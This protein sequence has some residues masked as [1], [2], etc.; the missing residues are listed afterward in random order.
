MVNWTGANLSLHHFDR[1]AP[2]YY[3]VDELGDEAAKEL[4]SE[5][6]FAESMQ[7][8]DAWSQKDISDINNIPPSFKKML[9]QMQHRPTWVNDDELAT[10]ADLCCRSG[11]NALV[12]LR[13]FTLMGGYDYAYLNKPLIFTGSLKKGATKRLKDTLN[14]WVNVTRPNGLNISHVGFKL[15]VITRLMHSYSRLMIL[16]KVK[17]WDSKK[18]GL[19]I[20]S[21]DMIATYIGFSLTFVL[22]LRKLGVK[23]SQKEEDSIFHLWNYVGYLIGIPHEFIPNN[24]KEATEQ[25]Y[26]WSTVQDCSDADSVMLAKSL[27][28]ENLSTPVYETM[29][30]RKRL[31][32]LHTCCIWYLLDEEVNH[33][34]EIP[35]V[36]FANA[37]PNMLRL[38]NKLYQMRQPIHKQVERGNAAQ[39]KILADYLSK[40]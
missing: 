10:A 12:I 22:G 6:S 3:Q 19:P 23:I 37:F 20:N 16:D 1:F 31:K 29:K 25:F 21:W 8:I 35:K 28:D 18:W 38:R 34:L 7:L 30:E 36:P 26:L 33:R 14:F 27:L 2:L 40:A 4:F 13:D 9:Q 32:Y 5:R 39:M 17:E 15:C 24:A 11:L